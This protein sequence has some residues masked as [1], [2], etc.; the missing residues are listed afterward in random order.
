MR[1]FNWFLKSPFSGWL[2]LAAMTA[3][4][5][6]IWQWKDMEARAARCD[7]REEIRGQL[8]QLTDRVIENL[9]EAADESIRNIRQGSDPCL[10]AP[11]PDDIVGS[12][13]SE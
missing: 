8:E 4:S 12:L 1:W 7:G 9:E 3:I 11:M 13:Q 5:V 2:A 6:I 10:D